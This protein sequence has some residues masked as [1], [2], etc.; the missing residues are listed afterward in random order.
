MYML[1]QSV[2]NSYSD[3]PKLF[4]ACGRKL[5]RV[6]RE[7]SEERGTPGGGEPPWGGGPE[8]LDP[9]AGLARPGLC[10]E[11]PERSRGVCVSGSDN[12]LV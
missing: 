9:E 10:V 8:R 7:V 2:Y 11:A 6:G 5:F 12:E 1:K 4:R 3:R